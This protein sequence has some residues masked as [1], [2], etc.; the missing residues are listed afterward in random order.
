MKQPTVYQATAASDDSDQDSLG[1][2]D[3]YHALL[4]AN[5]CYATL[6]GAKAACQEQTDE[7]YANISMPGLADKLVWETKTDCG[8]VYHE[9]PCE[10]LSLVYRITECPIL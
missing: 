8:V 4:E 3:A 10:G 2:K 1:W 7:D 9:A 5:P 6:D